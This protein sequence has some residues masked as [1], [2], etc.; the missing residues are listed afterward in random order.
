MEFGLLDLLQIIG[1][2]AFFIYG[3]KIMS[4]GIQKAAGSQLR[5]ILRTMTRNR[6]IG[7]FSGFMV[8][9]LL[10]SS[11]ATTVMVVSFANAGLLSL[12]ESIG[13][14][15]GANIGTTVT[16]WLISIFGFKVNIAAFSLPLMG[17]AMPLLFVNRELIKNIGETVMGFAILFLGLVYL[18]EAVPDLK[19]NPEVLEFLASYTNYGILSTILFIGIGT[20]LTVVIQSSSA[21]MALTLTLLFNGVITFEVA[22]AMVL[23]ENIGTTITANIAALV[24]NVHAKR[25]A[26]AHFIFNVMGVLWMIL[27]FPIFIKFVQSMWEPFQVFLQTFIPDLDKEQEELQLS[28][29]HTTFNIINTTLMIGFV[30]LI[31]KI[32]TKFVPVRDEEDDEFRLEYIGT[33][34]KTPE[35]SIVEA[36]KE[37]AKYGEITSRMSGFTKKLLISTEQKKQNKFLKKLEKYEDITDKLEIEITEFLTKISREDVSKKLSVR[38]RS[39]MN[40][41]NDLERMGDVFYQ[42]SKAIERKNEDRIWFN[43]HQRDRLNEMFG[44]IDQA[45]KIMLTNLNAEHYDDVSKDAADQIEQKINN[46]RDIMR[47]EN[48][49]DME[50]GMDY[51][52]NSAMVYNNLFS[53]L[54]KIGDHIMNISESI[55]GEI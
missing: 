11:S 51:N 36:Q 25:A 46:L 41:C 54:E 31:A 55:V 2:L 34:I 52:I 23:G 3:M 29:F 4:E 45:F 33:S 1:A 10:Q 40:V 28:L 6:F 15:M 50:S 22:A 37:V 39:I 8:T 16:A 5:N 7:V 9:A 20:I 49:N 19:N 17:I 35:L 14:I 13:V 44:L 18:K 27:L 30:P 32:V 24:G 38:I 21:A 48:L 43:Q 53:S 47:Q 12:I 42:M 26:R